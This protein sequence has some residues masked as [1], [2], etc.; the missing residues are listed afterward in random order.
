[1]VETGYFQGRCAMRTP[2]VVGVDGSPSATRAAEAAADLAT[3]RGLPLLVL[4]VFSWPALYPP[5]LPPSVAEQTN[6][7]AVAR[8]LVDTAAST[9]ALKR[10]DL[11]IDVRIVDGYPPAAL[12]DASRRAALVAVGH[13]GRGGFAELLT[14]SVGVHVTTHARCPVLVVRGSMAEPAAPIVVGADGSIPSRAAVR[15]A[16][17]EARSRGCEL[18]AARA[19]PPADSWP[20]PAA[21]NEE[22]A[23]QR[24]ADLVRAGLEDVVDQHPAVKVRWEVHHG[25]SAAH[26]LATLAD[27]LRAGAIVVGSRGVGGFRG[28]LMGGTCRAL[29]DH[30]PCPLIVVPPTR[31]SLGM[32]VW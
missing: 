20:D 19:L 27:D 14:G 8:Q 13:R 24:H 1:M 25:R 15:V 26:V 29:V 28:L 7:R 21:D 16:F 9:V 4:H 6:P 22:Q 10:P 5:F 17:E 32:E 31:H 11:D 18:V 12:V 30:A 23:G 2:V 3:R